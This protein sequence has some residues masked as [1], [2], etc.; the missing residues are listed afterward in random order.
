M[1]SQ[2]KK[3]GVFDAIPNHLPQEHPAITPSVPRKEATGHVLSLH[4][5][6]MKLINSG[7]LGMRRL[8]AARALDI[9]EI[10]PNLSDRDA[11]IIGAGYVMLRLQAANGKLT[12]TT[13]A[14]VQR[15]DECKH[16]R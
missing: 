8:A 11:Q 5:A 3:L 12:E 1:T 14:E 4:D 2:I 10:M 13:R 7:P 9:Q 16:L 6:E 15:V